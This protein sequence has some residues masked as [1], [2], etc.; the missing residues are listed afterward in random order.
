MRN[1]LK[2]T[3]EKF[4]IE[5]GY[6]IVIGIDEAGRGPLAGP[7]SVGSYIFRLGSDTIKGVNDSKKLT[8][9]RRQHLYSKLIQDSNSFS[10]QLSSNEQIDELGIS[11]CIIKS[12][13]TIIMEVE[14]KF[15]DA[16]KI[17]LIDGYFKK[18]FDCVY[19]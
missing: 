3:Y 15:S 18:K 13:S 6:D 1:F 2:P 19:Y 7:V 8:P 14:Q 11:N 4:L 17:F 16:K 5:K 12:I 10:I 9:L